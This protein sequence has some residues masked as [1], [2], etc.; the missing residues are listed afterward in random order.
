MKYELLKPDL[1]ILQLEERLEELKEALKK[2]S[3]SNSKQS[4]K[5][6]SL[7]IAQ[8]HGNPD[9]YYVNKDSP[10]AGIYIPRNKK[11]FAQ[12]LAQSDYDKDVIVLLKKEIKAIERFIKQTG[13]KQTQKNWT[14]KIQTLYSKMC[15]ARQEL[16]V[17]ITLPD[18]QY[19]AK[20]LDVKWG[21]LPFQ[22]DAPVYTSMTGV[23]VRSKSEVLIADALA[24]RGIPYRY[25]YPLI[26]QRP[27]T[28]DTIT[29]HP[30]F[31][32]LNLRTRQEFYWEHFGLMDSPE[33]AQ[34]A[35][36]KLHL[37]AENKIHPGKNLII[38]ME[39]QNEPLTPNIIE[40]EI[41]S[42]LK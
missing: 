13:V 15:R 27:H 31:L 36:S 1:L 9:Y 6:Y 22:P 41:V 37:Y 26:L 2:V 38:T 40:Q 8:K 32:C 20:W 21:G 14:S 18:E 30:D 19:K 16:V 17:P 39:T 7:R 4:L 23:R 35:T 34:T 24:R 12:Q 11:A 25:E 42:F 10:P 5:D 29:L 3:D 33:Y 28:N